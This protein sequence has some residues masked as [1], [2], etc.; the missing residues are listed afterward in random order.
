M[1]RKKYQISLCLLLAVV[2]LLTGCVTHY[3]VTHELETY[4]NLDEGVFIEP[5]VDGLPADTDPDKRPSPADLQ[6]L[7]YH[8]GAKLCDELRTPIRD[9]GENKSIY[10]VSGTVLSYKKGSGFLR[11]M[12]GFL[13]HAKVTVDLKLTETATGETL[14][15]ANFQQTVSDWAESGD[16]MFERVAKD[17]AKA[18]KKQL[19][20]LEQQEVS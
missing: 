3:R 14:F 13:G 9:V 12:F 10:T 19:K 2:F 5:I 6:K 7:V 1:L 15:A 17:F 4:V 11:F 16:K 8:I 20:K 18:I